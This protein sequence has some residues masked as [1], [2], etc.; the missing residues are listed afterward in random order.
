MIVERVLFKPPPGM[1]RTA[2]LEDAR[3]AIP[4]WRDVTARTGAEPVIRYFDLPM[5]VDS[6]TEWSRSGDA[7]AAP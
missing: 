4:R 1:E 5:V 7:R 2:V 6:V 3:R